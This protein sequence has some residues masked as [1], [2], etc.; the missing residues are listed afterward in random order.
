MATRVKG[1]SVVV[2]FL[3]PLDVQAA[4]VTTEVGSVLFT[5]IPRAI[6]MLAIGTTIG[7]ALPTAWWAGIPADA[8]GLRAG[9]SGVQ[10]CGS[11]LRAL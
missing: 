10:P 1:G 9:R 6:P 4:E 3:R 11:D 8:A 5:L 7:M 2:D